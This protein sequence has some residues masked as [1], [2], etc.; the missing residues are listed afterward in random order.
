[1][2]R[3]PVLDVYLRAASGAFVREVFVVDCGLLN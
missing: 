1:M 2:K 3:L